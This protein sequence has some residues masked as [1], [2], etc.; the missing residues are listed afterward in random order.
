MT[1]SICK[2]CR[3]T[4]CISKYETNAG[5]FT[6][7]EASIACRCGNKIEKLADDFR[8]HGGLAWEIAS[9]K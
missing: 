6:S 3:G 9:Y 5:G 4:P 8:G 7:V 2:L 1:V